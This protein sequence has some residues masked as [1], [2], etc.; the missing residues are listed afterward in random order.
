M[1]VLQNSPVARRWYDLV[2]PVWEPVVAETFWSA[3]LQRRL[4]DQCEFGPG[5]SVLDVGCGTAG[6]TGP[7]SSER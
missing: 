6:P 4:L 3:W 1:L 7:S 2:S 5:D